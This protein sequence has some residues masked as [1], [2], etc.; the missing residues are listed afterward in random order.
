MLDCWR[1]FRNLE[2]E[3]VNLPKL[4]G[5][6]SVFISKMLPVGFAGWLQI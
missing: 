4:K 1:F 2:E 3:F 5:R 6:D